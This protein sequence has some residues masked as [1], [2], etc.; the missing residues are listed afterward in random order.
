MLPSRK[1]IKQESQLAILEGIQLYLQHFTNDRDQEYLL[2]LKDSLGYCAGIATLWAYSKWLTTMPNRP[3]MSRDDYSWF[4]RTV[5][6]IVDLNKVNV[7]AANDRQDIERFIELIEFFQN[8]QKVLPVNQVAL[9]DLISD[10]ANGIPKQEYSIAAIFDSAQ[11]TKLLNTKNLIQ[12]HKLIIILSHNHATALFKEKSKYYYFDPNSEVGETVHGSIES[13]VRDI[14]AANAERSSLAND[15]ILEANYAGMAAVGDGRLCPLCFKIYSFAR[16]SKLYPPTADALRDSGV[17]LDVKIDYANKI[18]GIHLAAKLGS[19]ESMEYFIGNNVSVDMRDLYGST[20]LI[21]AATSGYEKGVRLLLDRG[22]DPNCREESSDWNALLYAV[23]G[24]HLSVVSVL[25]ERINDINYAGYDGRNSLMIAA[26]SNYREVAA[27]LIEYKANLDFVGQ[28]GFT[29]M[30]LAAKFNSFDVIKLLLA[31]GAK[32]G[33]V[34]AG[35][36]TPLMYAAQAGHLEVVQELLKYKASVDE[37]YDYGWSA[38]FAA[39]YYNHL[40]IFKSLMEY[41][42]NVNFPGPSGTTLLMC[43]VFCGDLN[44]INFL[45][46]NGARVNDR[47]GQG[48]TALTLAVQKNDAKIVGILLEKGDK[49]VWNDK[50]EVVH[51]AYKLAL[52]VANPNIVALL[53]ERIRSDMSECLNDD[54]NIRQ[55]EKD[56]L[57]GFNADSDEGKEQRSFQKP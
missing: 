8:P 15:N 5:D 48:N 13:L 7:L 41:G 30:M 28:H 50:N 17:A 54:E 53:F 55:S 3:N 29:P 31:H 25:V 36:W 10:T 12:E 42:V 56:S 46:E 37:V 22:A 4:L 16:T 18:S 49:V 19:L 35:A 57:E 43:A 44:T 6:L 21:Y 40:D 34:S 2:S 20:A 27:K 14:W 1:K 47:D 51:N 33:P 26:R 39:I 52:E 45:L 11:L 9:S 23:H 24:N 32:I 38:P